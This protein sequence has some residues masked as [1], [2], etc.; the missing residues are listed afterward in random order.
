MTGDESEV[1]ADHDWVARYINNKIFHCSIF[2]TKECAF[3]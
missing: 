1:N 3:M 2:K